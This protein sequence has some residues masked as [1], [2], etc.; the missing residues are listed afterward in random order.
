MV[1]GLPGRARMLGGAAG[2]IIEAPP[3]RVWSEGG[4]IASSGVG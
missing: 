2:N 3:S 4:G 1:G